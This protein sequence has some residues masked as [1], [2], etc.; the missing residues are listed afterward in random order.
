MLDGCRRVKKQPINVE[1]THTERYTLCG[2]E[3][4]IQQIVAAEMWR[5][6]TLHFAARRVNSGAITQASV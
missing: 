1:N 5:D 6:A 3:T 4:K 2:N